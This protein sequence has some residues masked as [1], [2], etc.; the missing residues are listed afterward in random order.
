MFVRDLSSYLRVAVTTDATNNN[1]SKVFILVENIIHVVMMTSLINVTVKSCFPTH[2]LTHS[3]ITISLE[4][5][6][7]LQ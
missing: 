2:S 1:L 4:L 6:N 5:L 7:G 3:L